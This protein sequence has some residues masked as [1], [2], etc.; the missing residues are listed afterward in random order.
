MRK[1]ND[2]VARY[3]AIIIGASLMGIHRRHSLLN[4]DVAPP[5]T[6]RCLNHLADGFDSQAIFEVRTSKFADEQA[7]AC[8][9]TSVVVSDLCK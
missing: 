9:R 5:E 3:D 4:L 8:I 1:T 6:D 7:V 2:E